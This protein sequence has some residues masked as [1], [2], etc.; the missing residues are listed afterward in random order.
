[1]D[2]PHQNATD[3]ELNVPVKTPIYIDSTLPAPKL[4]I[5]TQDSYPLLQDESRVN[6]LQVTSPVYLQE[7][8]ESLEIDHQ[9]A[10][11]K[12]KK[13]NSKKSPLIEDKIADFVNSLR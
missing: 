10:T 5:K 9:T 3:R 13:V 4:G 6:S 8:S 7:E 2:R 12:P 1:M 11:P